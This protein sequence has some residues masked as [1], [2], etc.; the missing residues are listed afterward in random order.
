[1]KV[2]IL[3]A[4]IFASAAANPDICQTAGAQRLKT[5]LPNAIEGAILKWR[6]QFFDRPATIKCRVTIQVESDLLLTPN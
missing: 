5:S 6:Q 2:L 3:A 4:V 1:M